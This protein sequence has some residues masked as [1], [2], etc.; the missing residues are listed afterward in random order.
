MESNDNWNCTPLH[1][2][3]GAGHLDI[4]DFLCSVGANLES[5]SSNKG[6]TPLEMARDKN[7]FEVVGLI[8][9]H[10]RQRS[11]LKS[12]LSEIKVSFFIFSEVEYFLVGFQTL[13]C[14]IIFFLTILC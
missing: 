7:K 3:A 1:N 2:A 13:N 14:S 9:E 11:K 8:Q 6:K 4:V 10:I 12:Q 5:R